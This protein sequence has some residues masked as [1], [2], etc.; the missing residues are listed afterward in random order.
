VAQNESILLGPLI[1]WLCVAI[2]RS[3]IE[4]VLPP[5]NARVLP[6]S[7]PIMEVGLAEKQRVMAERDLPLWNCTNVTAGAPQGGAPQGATPP[8]TGRN[9]A[10]NAILQSLQVLLQ[11]AQT[12]GTIPT[13]VAP[14]KVK[15]P[16]KHWEGTINLLLRLVGVNDEADLP[17]VWH[18][19]ANCNKKEARMV[20][21]EH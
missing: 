8:G 4:D 12:Q 16:S 10:Q 21:Q 11:Q 15:K 14:K 9:H 19:W 18:A 7:L 5:M 2:T 20:L 1:K 17:P 6:P 13:S 3:A